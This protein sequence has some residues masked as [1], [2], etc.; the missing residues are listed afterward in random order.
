MHLMKNAIFGDSEWLCSLF[1]PV[2]L[3]AFTNSFCCSQPNCETMKWSVLGEDRVGIFALRNI[4]VGTELTYSYNFEWYSGAK[5]RCLC[6]ATR[7]SGFLGGKPCG[8][9]VISI[10]LSILFCDTI[11]FKNVSNILNTNN[12]CFEN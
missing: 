11:S 9:Q 4:S 5:V 12:Q 2:S 1:N 10:C 3:M 7:C 6:G 8:F